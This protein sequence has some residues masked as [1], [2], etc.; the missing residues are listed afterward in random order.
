MK[1]P[2]SRRNRQTRSLSYST[3]LF[4]LTEDQKP[5]WIA[6]RDPGRGKGGYTPVTSA[7]AGAGDAPILNI[8]PNTKN[9]FSGDCLVARSCQE[10]VP[11]N[12]TLRAGPPFFLHRKYRIYP[13]SPPDLVQLRNPRSGDYVVI[14]R[15]AGCIVGH[16]AK[17]CAGVQVLAPYRSRGL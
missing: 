10:G 9:G 12:S 13:K 17:P 2:G 14:D 5:R 4:Q 11:K 16:S 8:P 3:A 6:R 15:A 1:T 7:G